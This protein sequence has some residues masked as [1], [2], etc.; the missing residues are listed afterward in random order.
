[1]V[2]VGEDG[3]LR[4]PAGARGERSEPR[5]SVWSD[6]LPVATLVMHAE[7]RTIAV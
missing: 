1:M 2:G 3:C 4:P 5:L 7:G 6:L